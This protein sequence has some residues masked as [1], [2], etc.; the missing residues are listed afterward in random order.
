MR[1]LHYLSQSVESI[2]SQLEERPVVRVFF[3]HIFRA[4][5]RQSDG[6]PGSSYLL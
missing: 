6:S 2:S 1:L 4:R 5:Y 3:G